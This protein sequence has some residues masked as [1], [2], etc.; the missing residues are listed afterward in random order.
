MSSLRCRLSYPLAHFTLDLELCV[1]PG[2]TVVLGPNGAGKSSLLRLLAGLNCPAGGR[3]ELGE[4]CLYEAG[5]GIE[6]P[7]EQR[8]IGLLFQDLALFPHLNVS[9]NIGFGLKLCGVGRG[10]RQRRTNRLL[11]K[12]AIT[13]L[14]GR[15]V[16]ELSGGE[17]QK[18]ALARTLARDPQL[19][20]LDEPTAALDPAAR[21]EIRRWLQLILA[22]LQIPTLLVSHDIDEAA[23]FRKRIAVM[24]QGRIVQQGSFHQLL[25]APASEYV[26]R[27]VGVNFIPGEVFKAAGKPVFRSLGGSSFFAPFDRV[28]PGPACLTVYP[29]EIALYRQLPDG[30]PRNHLHGQVLDAVLLGDRVRLTLTGKDKLVAELSHRGYLAL[31]APQ[32]GERLWAVFK[33]REARIDNTSGVIFMVT[34]EQPLANFP[35]LRRSKS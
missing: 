8:R 21:G 1:P 34:G 6:L 26:A 23:Y 22:E 4:R 11:E 32:P 24:E 31:G 7:P 10:E 5:K 35:K 9:G 28:A 16:T 13:H 19:L 2:I 20:L 33:A 29:W 27:F 30:S 25:R 12:L 15:R 18:V 3:I 14:A 17:R